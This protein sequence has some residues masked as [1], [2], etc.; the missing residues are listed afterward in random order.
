M[1]LLPCE[2]VRSLASPQAPPL[3]VD[4]VWDRFDDIR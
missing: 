1:L 4:A 3:R 2:G